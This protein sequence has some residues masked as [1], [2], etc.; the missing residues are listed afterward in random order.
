MYVLYLHTVPLCIALSPIPPPSPQARKRHAC[1]AC[2]WAVKE[3]QQI[4]RPAHTL[5]FAN[6]AAAYGISAIPY[7]HVHVYINS[8]YGQLST[9]GWIAVDRSGLQH[10][11]ACSSNMYVPNKP[12]S[13]KVCCQQGTP[14]YESQHCTVPST[15]IVRV[16]NTR[17]TDRR[18]V[19]W[20]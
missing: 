2:S 18:I 17:P 3:Q 10:S 7:V 13:K 5:L 12:I 14:E 20:C 16:G 4:P 8:L 9:A 6:H 1:N 11:R 15:C 19:W